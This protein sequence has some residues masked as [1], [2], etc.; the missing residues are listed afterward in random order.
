MVKNVEVV[1]NYEMFA[2]WNPVQAIV[3][4]DGI[5]QEVLCLP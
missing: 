3:K 1:K 4:G 2:C 5:M